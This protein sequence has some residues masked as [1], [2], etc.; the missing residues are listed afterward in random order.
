MAGHK[1][2]LAVYPGTFD[3]IML[4]QLDLI[5]RGQQL[6]A[7]MIVGVGINPDKKNELFSQSERV[8]MIRGLVAKWPHVK[9][10]AYSGLT[11]KFVRSVGGLVI[12]RG[13]RDSVDLRT[14]L[15]QANTNLLLGGV[16]TVFLHGSHDYALTS[17]TLIKQIVAMGGELETVERLVPP[18]VAQKLWE[19][20]HANGS[21]DTQSN[22]AKPQS[23]LAVY[24]GTFDPITLGHLDLI[25]RGKQL[26]REL[27]V[28]VGINPDKKDELFSHEER[29]EMIEQL[30]AKWPNVKVRAYKGLTYKFVRNVGGLTILRGIRDSV[31]LRLEL[32]QAN[33]NMLLGGIETVFLLGSHDHALTS[34]SLIKQIVALGGELETVERLVPAAVAQKLLEKIHSGTVHVQPNPAY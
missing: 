20:I 10:Q 22:G 27:I 28:G 30:V 12:L 29:V 15:L 17:S 1:G 33:T 21:A 2:R 32:L 26:F 6:F 5:E 16:E 3:P 18:Q 9:V 31:D 34:S 23:R 14:E 7:E 8:E 19:R 11:Y 24:P 13:I 4:G 25:E